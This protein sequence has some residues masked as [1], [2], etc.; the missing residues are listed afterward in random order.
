MNKTLMYV[1]VIILAW[2]LFF[3]LAA[4]GLP[5]L[6]KAYQRYA[7]VEIH[8]PKFGFNQCFAKV[9]L[10][11][12]WD[13]DVAGIVVRPGYAKYLVMYA[14]E[15]NRA[16]LAVKVGWEEEIR[17]FDTKYQITPCPESWRKHTRDKKP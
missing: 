2:I 7:A 16:T 17:A 5:Y 1:I 10:R 8:K 6:V 11:E 14:S 12:P 15:A 9:G 13:A 4:F 3:A